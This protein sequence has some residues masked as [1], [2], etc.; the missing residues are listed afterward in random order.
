MTDV[1]R[2]LLGAES[3]EGT[4]MEKILSEKAVKDAKG[5]ENYKR[6][7]TGTDF[8]RNRHL[9]TEDQLKRVTKSF[10]DMAFFL[11]YVDH[12][13]QE[14]NENPDNFFYYEKEDITE[15]QLK[16]Y[17]GF[18]ELNELG[19]R[20]SIEGKAAKNPREGGYRHNGPELK[21]A[22][23]VENAPNWAQNLTVKES[24]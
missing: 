8:N 3:L 11:G 14:N 16:S 23:I 15:E 12:P 6:K 20:L 7:Y 21:E 2:F 18:K 4:V 9:Y 5:A 19:L 13:D 1:F 22:G 24:K 17:M 10:E